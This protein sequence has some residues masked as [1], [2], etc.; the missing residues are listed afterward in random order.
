MFS[1]GSTS[2]DGSEGRSIEN[3][4]EPVRSV[5]GNAA[6][7]VAPSIISANLRVTGDLDSDGDIQIDGYVEGDVRSNSV[8]VGEH[9]V[10]SGAINSDRIIVAG[11]VKGQI[12]GKVVELAS[13]A[14]V[15][16]DIVHE[17]LAIEAGAFIQGLCRHVE[18]LGQSEKT[19]AAGKNESPAIEAKPASNGTAA[20]P[21]QAG[22]TEAEGKKLFG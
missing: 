12:H 1:K 11:T 4:V 5:R 13:T 2:K 16:G 14:K 21:P 17:S 9:A 10:V 22:K 7:S 8:T 19:T 20:V 15:T 3:R 18:T 6:A